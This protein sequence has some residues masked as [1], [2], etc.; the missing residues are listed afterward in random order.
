[1][2]TKQDVKSVNAYGIDLFVKTDGSFK[3]TPSAA[4]PEGSEVRVI[5]RLSRA[6]GA[7]RFVPRLRTDANGQVQE[8]KCA[9]TGIENGFDLYETAV[10][11]MPIG[12]YFLSATYQTTDGVTPFLF[13]DGIDA[14]PLTVHS[15]DFATPDKLKGGVMYQI[16]VDRF[17]KSKKHVLP[18]KEGAYL[19]PDWENG[20][21]VYPE[22]PG[23]AFNNN[24][25]FGGSLYGVAEKLDYLSS[26]GVTVLYL[27]PIFDAASNHKYDTSDY[28]K[29]DEMFGGEKA[30]KTLIRTAKKRGITI[31]LD[32]VFNHTGSDSVYFNKESRYPNLGAYQSKESPYYSWYDFKNYPDEYNCW[33]DVKILPAIKKNNDDFRNF[34]C[35]D[36]GVIRHYTKMGIGGWRLDV[37]DELSNAFLSDLR[38]SAKDENKDAIIIG[39]VWEDAS[40]KIAYDKRR[41]YFQGS[42]LD[43]VMNYPLRTAIIDYVLS[44]NSDIIKRCATSL[45]MHYP[46]C[47]SDVQ[48]NVLG[49]HD[50]ERILSMLAGDGISFKRNRE[51]AGYKMSHGARKHATELLKIA[52]FLLFTLPGIPCIYY[53]DEIGM[54]GGRDPFNR[55]PF[56]W[57]SQ[58]TE[59]RGHY[60]ALGALRGNYSEFADGE[61]NITYA[62]DGLFV[63]SREDLICAVNRG[64][65][66]VFVSERDFTEILSGK[67]SVRRDN[68]EYS[69][70]I[71]HNGFAIFKK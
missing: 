17:A 16:F 35:G 2:F 69:F 4:I 25:F 9:W 29:V 68:G 6:L 70:V 52:S 31:I 67:R 46:K 61:L 43:A 3:K 32:G 38:S 41:S 50:T 44:G 49:T 1:M 57:H 62:K 47:V 63:Y 40:D 24:C 27:N 26:L 48:M 54:E 20:I 39:E 45:Y 66:H 34:I 42:Q 55:L 15:K 11:V 65:E 23:D 21:P 30:L 12:L 51:L 37:A 14:L 5:F 7:F 71:P 59:I 53:G 13:P 10:P 60:E 56:A 8:L 36:N 22:T 58:D 28:L 19:D 33:W 18:V 64:G